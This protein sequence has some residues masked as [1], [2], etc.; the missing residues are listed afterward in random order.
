MR[1]SQN[2]KNSFGVSGKWSGFKL[3]LLVKLLLMY[4]ELWL[5]MFDRLT[6]KIWKP[7]GVFRKM[8]ELVNGIEVEF[9]ISC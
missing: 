2:Q 7:D 6:A 1:A 4:R 8:K 9:A 3:P 5:C